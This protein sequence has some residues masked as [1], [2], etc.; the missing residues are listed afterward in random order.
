MYPI[1]QLEPRKL[2]SAVLA[3]GVLT[4]DG[5]SR[6]DQISL[7]IS[8]KRSSRLIVKINNDEF[9]FARRDVRL[10]RINGGRGD[11]VIEAVNVN[12]VIDFPLS[13]NAGAG[14]DQIFAGEGN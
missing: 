11:D 6:G 9:S 2:L 7:Q 5:T 14:N 12:G 13:I 10:A 3:K 8:S 4:I 1:E